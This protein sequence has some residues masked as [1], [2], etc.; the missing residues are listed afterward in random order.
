MSWYIIAIVY[1]LNH[2]IS[3]V[4]PDL[5][6]LFLLRL[7]QYCDLVNSTK[8]KIFIYIK[9]DCPT[10]NI[11]LNITKNHLFYISVREINR[12]TNHICI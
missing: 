4:S 9:S 10:D 6:L 2:A 12:R 5:Y 11:E 3:T 7:I 1:A 8:Y